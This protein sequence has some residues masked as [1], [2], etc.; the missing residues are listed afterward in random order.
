MYVIQSQNTYTPDNCLTAL[1]HLARLCRC[2]CVLVALVVKPPLWG[3]TA[4]SWN[5][6]RKQSSWSCQPQYDSN[7]SDWPNFTN[8][9][10]SY[11]RLHVNYLTCWMPSVCF[12]ITIIYHFDSEW[13][14]TSN[15]PNFIKSIGSYNWLYLQVDFDHE[16]S[17][18]LEVISQLSYHNNI[19]LW[20]Q[21][22]MNI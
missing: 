9:I 10:G 22:T 19:S 14:C 1:G 11:N 5:G 13:P 6:Y 4:C 7:K 21:M 15:W 17:D 2:Y 18:F 20:Q 3:S 12:P 16:L 8:S